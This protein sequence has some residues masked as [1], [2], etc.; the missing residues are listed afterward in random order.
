MLVLD[1]SAFPD[2]KIK[3]RMPNIFPEMKYPRPPGNGAYYVCPDVS[4]G[5]VARWKQETVL[6]PQCMN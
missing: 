2:V 5:R 3:S 6:N 4:K 1:L